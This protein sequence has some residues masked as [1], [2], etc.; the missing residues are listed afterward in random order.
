MVVLARLL[1]FVIR[2]LGL[3][4]LARL[5]VGALRPRP[6]APRQPSE[7]AAPKLAGDLVRDRVCNTFV[8][9]DR[10][11]RAMVGPREELF[12]STACRD[13]ALAEAARAS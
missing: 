6:T 10:A 5:V 1:V 7:P 11:V 9:R 12:C 2:V 3:L 4:L 13:R 8:P